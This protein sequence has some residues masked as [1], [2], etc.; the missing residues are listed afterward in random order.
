MLHCHKSLQPYKRVFFSI[1][2]ARYGPLSMEV[3]FDVF[4]VIEFIIILVI[5]EAAKDKSLEEIA[6]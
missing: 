4:V 2:L 6:T 5:G 3:M 1:M